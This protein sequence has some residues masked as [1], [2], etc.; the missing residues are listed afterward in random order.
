MVLRLALTCEAWRHLAE[1]LMER[2]SHFGHFQKDLDWLSRGL[3]EI[4]GRSLWKAIQTQTKHPVKYKILGAMW[5]FSGLKESF[6]TRPLNL[7]LRAK[8]WK[9]RQT[10]PQSK[11]IFEL[12]FSCPVCSQ[13]TLLARPP[14]YRRMNR[15]TA[16]KLLLQWISYLSSFHHPDLAQWLG[17][18]S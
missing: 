10:C 1:K 9:D 18:E 13:L 6:Q 11:F 5:S 12:A 4:E 8:L 17:D 3:Q 15:F 2:L 7:L 14:N 16:K